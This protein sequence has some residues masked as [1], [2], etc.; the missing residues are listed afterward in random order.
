ESLSDHSLSR[1]LFFH[2]NLITGHSKP[3]LPV[4]ITDQ[5]FIEMF[6]GEV[7]PEDR[8]EIKLGI[9]DL[10]EEVITDPVF[11]RSPD[12]ELRVGHSGSSQMCIDCLLGDHGGID[13]AG[14][15][16]FGDPSA[17]MRDLPTR[18]VV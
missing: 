5:R 12:E 13:L 6:A 18:A 17:G 2:D 8:G 9:R 16:L 4:L 11:T 7:R 3:A 10:P 15:H 14:L 1:R